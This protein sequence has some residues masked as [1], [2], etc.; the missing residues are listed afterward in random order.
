MKKEKEF[1][2]EY[3]KLCEKYR[4][5][6]SACGCCDSPFLY[7]EEEMEEMHVSFEENLTE[8]IIHLEST[9]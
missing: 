2:I 1:L 3:K 6:I 5:L 7:S 4:I 9:K 8:N